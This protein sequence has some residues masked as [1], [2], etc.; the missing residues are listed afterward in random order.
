ML[1]VVLVVL[2]FV[3]LLR[4]ALPVLKGTSITALLT[5][6]EWY[7]TDG[8]FGYLPLIMGS[9][10]VTLGAVA[11]AI[12][13]GVAA[14]VYVGEIAPPR[15]REFLKPAIEMVAAVPSV[16][17]GFIGLVTLGPLLQK[18]FHMSSGSVALTGSLML[19]FMAL[20]TIVSIA[21]DALASVPRDYRSGSL[22]LGATPWQT[23][24]RV[25]LPAAR[26]GIVAA[27]MLGVG[28]AIGETMTVLMVTGNAFAQT[29][30]VGEKVVT[31]LPYTLF[32]PVRTMTAT[33]A[34]EMGETVQYGSHYSA[35]FMLGL[36]LFAITFAINLVAD[37]ALHRMPRH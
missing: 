1:A 15:L 14:A 32:Q 34:A 22:A 10:I 12:P 11:I 29:K 30:M 21:E 17:I 27:V 33:I 2:I 13:I 35:L 19:A 24:W 7:P 36:C 6:R 8:I 23:I 4:D 16:V 25:Q 3:F 31:V 18:W 9:A 20:P 37:I 28:R 26:P 5:G